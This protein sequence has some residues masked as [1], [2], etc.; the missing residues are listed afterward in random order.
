[1][2]FLQFQVLKAASIK[3]A[4]LWVVAPCSLIEVYRRFIGACS[5]IALMV[6]AAGKSETSVDFHQTIRSNNPEDSHLNNKLS[7]SNQHIVPRGIAYMEYFH[8]RHSVTHV[9]TY[10]LWPLAMER[11]LIGLLMHA[12]VDC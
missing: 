5:L 4:V 3:R 12:T 7:L 6:E 2:N 8:F 9:L 10:L 11:C 1:M